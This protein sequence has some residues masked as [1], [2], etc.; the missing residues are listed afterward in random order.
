MCCQRV[1]IYTGCLKSGVTQNF[2]VKH[3]MFTG[4]EITD[5]KKNCFVNIIKF[6]LKSILFNYM[7]RVRLMFQYVLTAD[8]A[9][10]FIQ[11]SLVRRKLIFPKKYLIHSYGFRTMCHLRAHVE[12]FWI[13]FQIIKVDLKIS[14]H[15]CN[16]Q[17]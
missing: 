12:E 7:Y 2:L 17:G 14:R 8:K 16:T 1:T 9:Q 13:C 10:F 6:K 4:N 3:E 5:D 11:N 15:C